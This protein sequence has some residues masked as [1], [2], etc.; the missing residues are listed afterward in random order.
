MR[1]PVLPPARRAGR[2]ARRPGVLLP[3]ALAA[4]FLGG[5][6]SS[7]PETQ[8]GANLDDAL[9]ALARRHHVCAVTVAVVK[10]GKL[11]AVRSAS[12]CAPAPAVDADS[13]FQAASLS[14]PLFAYA[15][16]KLVEQGKMALDAPVLR[17]LPQGYR[18]RFDP[19]RT[20]PSEQVS[21]PRLALVTVRMLLNHTSGFPNWASGPLRFDTAPGSRWSYSG[22]GYLLLQ[23]AVEAV[24][25]QPLDVFM[26]TQVFVPLAMHHSDYVRSARIAPWLLP[27]T[28][29]NGAPRTTLELN[30][31]LAAFSLHT[32]AAD[33][34]KFLATLLNDGPHLARLAAAPVPA[35]AALDIG[36]GLGWG[37][38]DAGGERFIWHWGNNTGYRAFVIASPG[39]GDGFVMLTNSENGLK[40]AQPLTQVLL[41]GAHS[42]FQFSALDDDILTTACNR[43]S[44]CL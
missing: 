41:P 30:E 27:G 40:L 14:K 13:V 9:G 31:P 37:T 39:T 32:S 17:Y 33:Y 22:E 24:S 21:D 44:L 15:V 35:D 11:D 5:C 12:G 3:L 34:G 23:R 2:S 4:I 16:L 1:L 20:E 10:G 43:L 8:D 6:V 26:R 18:H 19:L 38:E 28:K 36:W 29:A 25:G 7:R 42:V